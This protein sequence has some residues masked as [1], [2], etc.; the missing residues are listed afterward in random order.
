[1]IDLPSKC[2]GWLAPHEM[3]YLEIQR[4]IKQG[5]LDADG[6]DVEGGELGFRGIQELWA[7]L[8]NWRFGMIG[9]LAACE[10]MSLYGKC[11][12]APPPP[13]KGFFFQ[14]P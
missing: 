3:R 8:K 7:V 11:L 12:A 13:P 14:R 2:Q 10:I 1:M 5:G 6:S 9:W 4:K